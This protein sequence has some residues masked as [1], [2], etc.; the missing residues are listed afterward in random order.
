MIKFHFTVDFCSSMTIS[1][2]WNEYTVSVLYNMYVFT[3]TYHLQ[4]SLPKQPVLSYS[5]FYRYQMNCGMKGTQGMHMN[6]CTNNNSCLRIF[7][8]LGH[9]LR[10]MSFSL[11]ASDRN[12]CL[13]QWGG[14]LGSVAV[15]H[16]RNP[17]P[18]DRTS[19]SFWMN[20]IWLF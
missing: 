14:Y 10:L 3:R 12:P 16:V 2:L 6:R 1:I 18:S 11:H 19:H 9:C 15:Q 7:I 4:N 5:W 8:P 13:E 17:F 20:V